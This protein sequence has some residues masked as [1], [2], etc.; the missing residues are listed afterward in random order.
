MLT[1]HHA[2]KGLS[3]RDVKIRL[4]GQQPHPREIQRDLFEFLPYS[5]GIHRPVIGKNGQSAPS[6]SSAEAITSRFS[7]THTSPRSAR[8]SAVN[9]NAASAL[10]PSPFRHRRADVSQDKI[11]AENPGPANRDMYSSAARVTRFFSG[12]QSSARPPEGY[13]Q[14]RADPA[15]E[16]EV[17]SR[18]SQNRTG[19]AGVP[20]YRPTG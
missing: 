20:A 1:R 14:G 18:M 6:V 4:N 5:L 3:G 19:L 2:G 11:R 12:G 8:A 10:P 13:P 15:P 9:V 17:T 7:R 16:G